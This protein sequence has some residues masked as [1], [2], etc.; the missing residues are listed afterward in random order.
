[1]RNYYDDLGVSE[2]SSDAQ[3]KSAYR[4]LAKKYHPDRTGGDSERFKQVSEAHEIL[5]DKEKRQQYDQVR[6]YGPGFGG[7]GM[8]GSQHSESGDFGDIF[9]SIFGDF[10]S[11]GPR[12]QPRPRKG[13]DTLVHVEIPFNTAILGG[14]ISIENHDNRRL[15][16]KIPPGLVSGNQLRLKGQGHA[17]IAG[18]PKGD[19]RVEVKVSS[20]PVF[21][22][23]GKNL[24]SNLVIN[25]IDL[26]LGIECP[27]ETIHG[28]VK[29]KV[30]PGLENGARLRIKGYGVKGGGADGDHFVVIRPQLPK[31]ITAEE[32]KLLEQLRELKNANT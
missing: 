18:G 12:Q 3:I 22:R 15:A 20:H 24:L 6:K 27:V 10:S 14:E 1:M 25:Y 17:G 30:P 13:Q 5:S 9:S 32:K 26:I 21:W 19:I 8:G 28:V 11:G 23:E 4:K 29:L 7:G 31:T 16:V 2:D